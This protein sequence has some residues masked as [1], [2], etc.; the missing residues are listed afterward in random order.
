MS[1][2]KQEF[3]DTRE[4]YGLGSS[5]QF[6]LAEPSAWQ[7]SILWDDYCPSA[8]VLI[9]SSNRSALLRL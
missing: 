6:W 1:A 9:V 7:G 2:L 8:V 3:A 5:Q 4:L